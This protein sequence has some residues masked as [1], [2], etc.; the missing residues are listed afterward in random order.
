MRL[1]LIGWGDDQPELVEVA[2]DLQARGHEIAYWTRSS[3]RLAVDQTRFPRT[4]FHD[5]AEVVVGKPASGVVTDDFPRLSENFIKQFL[6]YESEVITMMNKKYEWMTTSERKHLYYHFLWYW[7]GV[8][9]KYKPELI[10]F[11]IATH[12]LYDF[13]LYGLAEFYKIPVVL[14]AVTTINPHLLVMNDFRL[15]CVSLGAQLRELEHTSIAVSDL[16][17]ALQEY[18][19]TQTGSAAD[20]PPPYLKKNIDEYATVKNFLRL[21]SQMIIKSFQDLSIVSKAIQYIF[22]KL[23]PNVK[24]EYERVQV[25]PDFDKKFIYVAL[26]YQPECATSPLGGI[27]VDQILMIEI[28]AAALPTGWV[29]YVKEHPMQ[30]YP[31]GTNFTG[32]RYQGYYEHLSKIKNVFIVP[33]EVNNYRLLRNCQVVA[34][35]TG[36]SGWEGVLRLKPAVVFGYAWY[37]DCPGV[38]KVSDVSS[39]QQA[40][41]QIVRGT[42]VKHEGVIKFLYALDRVSVKGYLDSYNEHISRLTPAENRNNIVNA[43]VGEIEKIKNIN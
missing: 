3:L 12:T 23:L 29:I 41:E 2:A 42:A 20:V 36:S 33:V 40:L 35:I 18:F 43:F 39:C 6:R 27:F 7:N 32:Y 8:I 10:I 9:E 24:D 30:W 38:F 34:T 5:Y 4:I 22:K 16:S 31:R 28:L 11:P 17:P 37:R 15:G 14:F 26:H 25:Q 21:K 1:F 19:I 13:V